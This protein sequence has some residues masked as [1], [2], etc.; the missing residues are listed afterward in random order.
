VIETES[1]LEEY[2][3]V[4]PLPPSFAKDA[5]GW[6]GIDW[7]C[8]TYLYGNVVTKWDRVSDPSLLFCVRGGLQDGRFACDC[9]IARQSQN[10]Q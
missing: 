5:G 7:L 4:P 2:R 6:E 10:H 8:L 1:I 9:R 3:H